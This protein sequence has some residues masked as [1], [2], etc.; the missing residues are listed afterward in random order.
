MQF[1]ENKINWIF[2]LQQVHHQAYEIREKNRLKSRKRENI[3]PQSKT[4]ENE[5]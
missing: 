2:F 4:F 3:N 1:K 5:L